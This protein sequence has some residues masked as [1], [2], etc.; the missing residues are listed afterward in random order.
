MLG[1]S[2]SLLLC[3]ALSHT[4]SLT[5]ASSSSSSPCAEELAQICGTRAPASYQEVFDARVCLWANRDL[6]SD[7]CLFH[8]VRGSPS[9]VEP[10][11]EAI[12]RHCKDVRPGDNRVHRCLQEQAKKDEE[13]LPQE[14]VAALVRDLEEDT[15]LGE[16][17]NT[18][19]DNAGSGE[20]S[21]AATT[22]EKE[23][24][25]SLIA[26][27]F[28][29]A[30]ERESVADDDLALPP[31]RTP[32]LPSSA[33]DGSLESD[34]P[35]HYAV[36]CGQKIVSNLMEVMLFRDVLFSFF[37]PSSASSS[38]P[39]VASD[40]SSQLFS[41][42]HSVD[43]ART[44]FAEEV[45]LIE[46]WM[47]SVSQSLPASA[48]A[49]ASASSTALFANHHDDDT[50]FS[51]SKED[52]VVPDADA[53]LASLAESENHLRIELISPARQRDDDNYTDDDSAVTGDDVYNYSSSGDDDYN[54]AYAESEYAEFVLVAEQQLKSTVTDD[55]YSNN[56][57][58]NN[59]NNNV[60]KK[61][62]I[63]SPSLRGSRP[64]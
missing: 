1:L 57:K 46:H 6:L 41:F 52:A 15:L 31:L 23:S 30:G 50:Q 10:C 26:R 58:N 27:W 42:S 24:E 47:S 36:R 40:S 59:D 38:V 63:E 33:A 12:Q 9:V 3:G 44:F 43:S 49:S 20:T 62:M 7:A 21:T 34:G 17:I 60:D 18:S 53:E 28:A 25:F 64:L 2:L 13:A 45:A 4:L 55:K 39:A 8:V 14:C 48:S 11:F 29:S 35:A 56:N 61:S 22:K 16:Y 5:R 32:V 19:T 51:H 37:S 54:D